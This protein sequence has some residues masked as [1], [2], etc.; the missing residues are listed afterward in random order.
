ML[1][2][3]ER[4][5]ADRGT[6]LCIRRD[7]TIREALTLMV[8]HDYSQLPVIDHQGTLL[9]M[10]SDETINRR[11]LYSAGVV[12]LLDLPVD[13]CVVKP[14]ILARDRD[15]F[16]ALDR[17]QDVYAI[18]I[19]S[20]D[21]RPVGILTSFDMAHFFR[22]LTEDLLIVEDIETSLRQIVQAVLD[23]DE[24]LDF[25]LIAE[26]GEDKPIQ[27]FLEKHSTGWGSPT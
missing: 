4:L 25:A 19:V 5:L 15:I 20:E 2:P 16:E 18:V 21:N 13:H 1:F 7:Q 27:A 14:T 8:Q 9:G 22:D 26:F 24:A 23:T 3:I 6:L 10:I 17:L 11:Y 12:T